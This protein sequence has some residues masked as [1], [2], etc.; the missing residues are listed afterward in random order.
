MEMA[1]EGGEGEELD[2]EGWGGGV[3]GARGVGE[4]S[5]VGHDFLEPLIFIILARVWWPRTANRK[6]RILKE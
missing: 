5:L 1:L 3:S 2:A 6:T 4:Y